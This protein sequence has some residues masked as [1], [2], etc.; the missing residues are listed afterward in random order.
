MRDVAFTSPAKGN[1][2]GSNGKPSAPSASALEVDGDSEDESM[3]PAQNTMATETLFLKDSIEIMA[4]CAE[5]FAL[6]LKSL[7]LRDQPEIARNIA[8]TFADVSSVPSLPSQARTAALSV[9]SALLSP[10]HG[11][12]REV[13]AM[14]FKLLTPHTLGTLPGGKIA[15]KDATVVRTAALN[16][17]QSSL[18]NIQG[19]EESAA[20]FMRHA[21]LK[22]PE[23]ADGR[24]AAV[25]TAV[26]LCKALG[27]QCLHCF[28]G[29]I[30]KLS[31]TSKANQRFMA[32][33][34]SA[35]FI[36]AF[37]SPFD[38]DTSAPTH[39]AASP[40]PI[41]PP[42]SLIKATVTGFEEA[43]CG[44]IKGD[45]NNNDQDKEE[46]FVVQDGDLVRRGWVSSE[47]HALVPAPWGA[48]L[49]AILRQRSSDKIPAVRARA[50]HH[51]AT[52]ASNTTRAKE[53]AFI[54]AL[55]AAEA[56][57][58]SVAG[59]SGRTPG[60]VTTG[61]S[62][63]SNKTINSD[64]D[65][66]DVN[67]EPGSKKKETEN[68]P[69]NEGDKGDQGSNVENEEDEKRP[70]SGA[71]N[72]SVGTAISE[73]SIV[74][75]RTLAFPVPA[76]LFF[77]RK[78][79][80]AAA[81]A[82][83]KPLLTMAR[84]RCRD[85]KGAVRKSA[86]QLLQ[87]LIFIEAGRQPLHP[88]LEPRDVAALEAA[89]GDSLLT[90]RKAALLAAAQLAAALPWDGATAE[91]WVSAGLPLIRDPE[92]V[93]QD[94]VVDQVEELILARAARAGKE[95]AGEELR[96]VLAAI[97]RGGAAGRACLAR[98]C[99]QLRVKNR[100]QAKKVTT[101]LEKMLVEFQQQRR[102]AHEDGAQR[103]E[104]A[105]KVV[106]SSEEDSISGTW[107]LYAEMAAQA[108]SAP[109]WEFLQSQWAGLTSPSTT[110][111][112]ICAVQQSQHAAQLLR[113]IA[114][115]AAEFPPDQALDLCAQL[116]A[117]L[118]TLALTPGSAA[119][120]VAALAQ[121]TR[122]AHGGGKNTTSTSM[123][124]WTASLLSLCESGLAASIEAFR[125]CQHN[126]DGGLLPTATITAA[127]A[128]SGA[129]SA[130][131]ITGEV[132]L[133]RASSPSSRLVTLVQA[134]TSATL[135]A[136][137]TAGSASE[138][139]TPMT[140]PLV[141][142]S[143]GKESALVEGEIAAASAP[144]ASI[145]TAASV[146]ATVQALAWVTLGKL[147]LVNES[148][149]KKCVPLFV[150][151]LGRAASPAVRNNIMVALADL[152]IN[153]TAL[154]D[155]HIPRLAAC[156]RD[157]NE[158]VRTQALGLLAN[159]LQKDYVK[160]RGPLFLRFMLA[161]I[162]ESPRVAAMAEFLLS[163]ALDSKLPNLAYN[164]FVEALFAL[165]DCQVGLAGGAA[166]AA[167]LADLPGAA[168]A[169]REAFCLKGA[170]PIMR[171]KRDAIYQ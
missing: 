135:A 125:C 133:L 94:A 116:R 12:I 102:G 32:V 75:F 138:R 61:D 24:A 17:I 2:K 80:N 166:A 13:S 4:L 46:E 3:L 92:S 34:L 31:R 64:A 105:I 88:V 58:L 9:L 132:A 26:T 52:L 115:A 107:I 37:E 101:G 43:N 85:A 44:N 79:E 99:A 68:T 108:P 81:T 96:P 10:G 38:P 60:T 1:K 111:T 142:S 113:V 29:F 160:W 7:A 66:D 130:L 36:E 109:S 18:K 154:V 161:L 8:E 55:A 169:E 62:K 67:G 15:A 126:G 117:N 70:A 124:T 63:K 145:A 73:E 119:A 89:A 170:D 6:M 49:L 121:L 19:C 40:L 41:L 149:A 83:L 21:V 122:T 42:A 16:F 90:V 47:G 56:V 98:T 110:T 86:V 95:K 69:Q 158:L 53:A 77:P 128:L 171:S 35:A 30:V 45:G 100:L 72:A 78:E 50:L 114:T 14:V 146:P 87:A 106:N 144:S 76:A 123:A 139:Q 118:E 162:D 136:G 57:E 134:L 33:E 141:G 97:S 127:A 54:I 168:A 71:G 28:V 74:L 5:N 137:L 65:G 159:L 153:Y 82:D 27:P 22:T 156:L 25:E 155:S 129:P 51:I 120:H 151:E 131:F 84:L 103:E 104:E 148:L 59:N 167:A 112:T 152:V 165:N 20:A 157:P 164:H 91:L 23:K 93:I 39:H 11:G 163:D 150:Q 147:C 48:V 140:T 143:G